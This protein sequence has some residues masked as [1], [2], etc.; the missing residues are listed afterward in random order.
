VKVDFSI[1]IVFNGYN[2]V[3]SLSVVFEGAKTG[4]TM[5]LSAIDD[6]VVTSQFDGE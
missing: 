3:L 4:F 5:S 6:G 2:D 1:G